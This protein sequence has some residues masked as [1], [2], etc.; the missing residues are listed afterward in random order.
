MTDTVITRIYSNESAANAVATALGEQ[1][2]PD[3][4]FEVISGGGDV[5][6]RMAAARVDAAEAAVYA[7]MI[8]DGNAL[9]VVRAPFN[10][11]GAARAAMKTVDAGGPLEIAVENANRYMGD[12]LDLLRKSDKVQNNVYWGRLIPHLLDETNS[13][14]RGRAPF[15]FS[16]DLFCMPTIKHMYWARAAGHLLNESNSGGQGRAPFRFSSGMF[17]IP[18]IRHRYWAGIVGHILNESNSGGRGRAPFRFSSGI[19]NIPHIRHRYWAQAAGHLLNESNSG[20]RGRAPFRFSSGLFGIPLL[21][22]RP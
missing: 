22:K 11:M 12:D 10:P 1:N 9:V 17:G 2:F 20:G 4:M 15:R 19:L 6:A 16:S 7:P 18:H 13:G 5:D 8:K 3:E 14:G 21:V